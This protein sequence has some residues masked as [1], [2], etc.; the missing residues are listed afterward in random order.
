MG[1]DDRSALRL[2]FIPD[3]MFR[4]PIRESRVS[5]LPGT[6]PQLFTVSAP[7]LFG[8]SNAVQNNPPDFFQALGL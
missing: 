2:P 7:Q 3:I 4:R 8:G 1:D 5:Y 6:I